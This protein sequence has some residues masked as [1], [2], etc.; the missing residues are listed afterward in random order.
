MAE[1]DKKVVNFDFFQERKAT[2]D[3][4][5]YEDDDG[6]GGGPPIGPPGGDGAT[7]RAPFGT[8]LMLSHELSKELG[9]DWICAWPSKTWYRWDGRR[10]DGARGDYLIQQ[11]AQQ[12]ALRLAV[13][14]EEKD[15]RTARSLCR[16]AT[17]SGAI[18]L[19]SSQQRHAVYDGELDQEDD[20]E[21]NTPD[22]LLYL[23]TGFLAPHV[24]SRMLTRLTGASPRPDAECPRWMQFLDEV[25]GGNRGLQEYLRRMA[26]YFLT[27]SI[28]EHKIFF[29]YGK[30]RTG[31]TVFQNILVELLGDYAIAAAMDMFIVAEGQRHLTEQMDLCGPRLVIASETQ[32]GKRWNDALLKQIAGG[33]PMRARKMRENTVQF[34]THCKL[35]LGG[36]HRPRMRPGDDAMRARFIV[37][38][39]GFRQ[40][41]L[42]KDLTDKLRGELPGIFKWAMTGALELHNGASLDLSAAPLVIREATDEY[43]ESQDTINHWIDA[44]C[45]RGGREFFATT[46]E[47][48]KSFKG[49]CERAG[50]RWPLPMFIFASRLADVDGVEHHRPSGRKARGFVG[51]RL[52][53]R[54]DDFM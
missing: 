12:V 33:D 1:D 45:E 27:G 36:N 19:I 50:D 22:G 51:L 47:L 35:L 32:E 46:E 25:T 17:I 52:N 23:K 2:R 30:S 10:W 28:T 44:C 38:P 3:R 42:D 37:P 20:W 26:G 48:Y 5:R 49:W 40:P 9:D 43:F 29:L 8:E 24:R 4:D 34:R 31:K 53:D 11:I 7:P 39:F 15:K 54:Q 41:V 18:T 14:I 16:S 21:I 6:G 13:W